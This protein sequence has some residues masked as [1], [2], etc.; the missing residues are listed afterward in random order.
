MTLAPSANA[1]CQGAQ[2]ADAFACTPVYR[3]EEQLNSI[4][5]KSMILDSQKKN[6][7]WIL[8][9][10]LGAQGVEKCALSSFSVV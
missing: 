3:D 5:T 8:L 2:S 10:H 7:N 4:V 9:S 1:F 6:S